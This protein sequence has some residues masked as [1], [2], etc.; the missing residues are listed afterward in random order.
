M[1]DPYQFYEAR[2]AGA[3]AVLLIAAILTTEQIAA[4]AGAGGGTGYGVPC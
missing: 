2:L 4:F 3:D 1:I